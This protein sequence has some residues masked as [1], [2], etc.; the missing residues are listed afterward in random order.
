MQIRTT[1]L[2]LYILSRMTKIERLIRPHPGKNVEQ[3]GMSSIASGN[4]KFYNHFVN[5]LAIS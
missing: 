1:I 3:H 2:R 5:S 4:A